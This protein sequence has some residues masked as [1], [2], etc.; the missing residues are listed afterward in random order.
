[1]INNPPFLFRMA[2]TLVLSSSIIGC[3]KTH[4]VFNRGTTYD[5]SNILHIALVDRMPDVPVNYQLIDWNKRARDFDAFIYDAS[6]TGQ[7]LPI[8]TPDYSNSTFKIP[9]YVGINL[10][11]GGEEAVATLQSVLGATLVGIDKSNQ[12]GTD[13]VT[14]VQAYKNRENVITNNPKQ[15]SGNLEFWYALLPTVE[16]GALTD[17]YSNVPGMRDIMKTVA[18]RWYDAVVSLG[19]SNVNFSHTGYD[20]SK[21][22]PFDRRFGNGGAWIEPDAAAGAGIFLYWAFQAFHDSKY[23]DAATWCTNFLTG[24]PFAPSYE[25]II[26]WGPLL[27]ARLNAEQGQKN[28]I[29]KL[30]RQFFNE[31]SDVRRGWGM[32]MGTWGNYGADGLVGADDYS[33]GYAFA[34]NSFLAPMGIA[35]VARYDQRFARDIG[36]WILNVASN[37]RL[38]YADLL[39]AQNQEPVVWSGDP[40]HAIPYEGLRNNYMNQSPYATGDPTHYGWGPTDFGIYSGAPSGVLGGIIQPTNI[41][42]ILRIDILKTDFFHAAAYPTYLYYNPFPENKTVQIDGLNKAYDL[43]DAVTDSYLATDVTGPT[44]FS[45]P[46]KNA[47]VAVL[48]PANGKRVHNS[49]G[50]IMINDVLVAFRLK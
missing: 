12:N 13:Y 45:V 29:A 37:A 41:D 31:S 8:I 38:F 22:Q 50:A 27:G 39:P 21:M 17:L 23:L 24:L 10:P 14:Q 7:Y 32:R 48:A 19:G 2:I 49:N 20:F 18:E 36:K 44:S 28:D 35:P 11:D 26:I 1:M 46:A 42:K 5:T 25:T 4:A 34:M 40:E 9:A 33:N 16:F 3:S 43:Y 30:M 15:L 6:K 47:V